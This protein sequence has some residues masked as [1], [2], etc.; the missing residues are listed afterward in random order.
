MVFKGKY[1]RLTWAGVISAGLILGTLDVKPVPAII[2]A[3]AVNGVLLP[4]VAVFLTLAVNDRQ[5]IPR[6]FLNTTLVN[7]LT[8]LIVLIASFLGLN[9]L[10]RAVVQVIPQWNAH[11]NWGWMTA[12]AG[13]LI[14][15]FW[16][17]RQ[18]FKQ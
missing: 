17:G 5:L 11:P 15:L 6:E 12:G 3:Q 1:F 14:I 8:L 10:W 18:I 13:S 16:L 2:L 4:V 9:N 7:A